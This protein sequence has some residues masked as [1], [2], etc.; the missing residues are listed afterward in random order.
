MPTKYRIPDNMSVCDIIADL[1][2]LAPHYLV[3]HA[4]FVNLR[5]TVYDMPIIIGTYTCMSYTVG[6]LLT[7]ERHWVHAHGGVFERK[8]PWILHNPDRTALVHP[9]PM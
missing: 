1:A 8:S 5:S 7:S 4:I 6:N 9:N 2:L 3:Q